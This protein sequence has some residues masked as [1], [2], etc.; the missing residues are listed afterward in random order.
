MAC[1]SFIL[2][3]LKVL[4]PA[5]QILNAIVFFACWRD[6]QAS[7]ILLDDKFEVRLGSLSEVHTQ[8]GDSHQNALTRFLRKPQY[9]PHHSIF[10]LFFYVVYPWWA[11]YIYIYYLNSVQRCNVI[12]FLILCRISEQGPA[13][14]YIHFHFLDTLY[15]IFLFINRLRCKLD[16]LQSSLIS[17]TYPF[18]WGMDCKSASIS[19]VTKY[20]RPPEEWVDNIY[21]FPFNLSFRFI[22]L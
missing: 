4:C 12:F 5:A 18:P 9:V 8:D 11:I 2:V 15:F 1:Q 14:A 10:A 16:M 13:G 19:S 7:S 22:Q 6:V 3:Y 21:Y 20:S 17:P